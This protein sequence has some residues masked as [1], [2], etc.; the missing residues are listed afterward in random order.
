[1]D[2][3]GSLVDRM[4]GLTAELGDEK[5]KVSASTALVALA[6]GTLSETWTASKADDLK[7]ANKKAKLEP[8]EKQFQAQLGMYQDEVL[9]RIFGTM[10][11]I[12]QR[13][14][15]DFCLDF[16]TKKDANEKDPLR[17]EAL[18]KRRQA[19]LAA[20]EA[21]LDRNNPEDTKRILTIA[22]SDAPDIV[23]DQAFKRL[24]ELP[25]EQVVDKLYDLYKTDKWKVRRA[26]GMTVLKMSTVK[27]LDEFM[28]KLPEGGA[29]K[30]FAMPEA[31]AYGAGIGDLKDGKPVEAL[32][33]WFSSGGA[34]A[35]ATA[36]AYWYTYGTT[37]DLSQVQPFENDGAKVPACETDP[38]C[39]WSCEIAKE[40]AKDPA[41]E[42]ESKDIKTLGD[43]VKYCVEPAMK[44]RQPEAKK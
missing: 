31:L 14:V 20:L 17:V 1:M 18:N 40:G 24:G 21:R 10:R 9:V 38:D 22:S 44:E 36:L 32:K 5:T 3:K 8:T 43:F 37:A 6:K 42:R 2:V 12:G 7:Q 34:T 23:L 28:N 25:R 33:K 19:A 41:K 27:N 16:A 26:A 11:K 4:V 29:A 39:K 15:I 35:R 13:P 30:G